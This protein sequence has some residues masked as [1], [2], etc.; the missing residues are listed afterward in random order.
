M[1][2]GVAGRK[3]LNMTSKFLIRIA[4]SQRCSYQT[5]QLGKGVIFAG[6]AAQNRAS[7]E[8]KWGA[9]RCWEKWAGRR[10]EPG[11]GHLG[12]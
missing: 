8:D 7:L 5:G 6:E 9:Q 11:E 12:L 10:Q 4:G 1:W 3:L 2:I